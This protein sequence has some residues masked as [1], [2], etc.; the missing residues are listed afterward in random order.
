MERSCVIDSC[1]NEY[2]AKGYCL[3]HYNEFYRYN[4]SNAKPCTIEGCDRFVFGRG[5]CRRHYDSLVPER[6]VNNRRYRKM[7]KLRNPIKVKLAKAK[8]N[9]KNKFGWNISKRIAESLGGSKRSRPWESLVGYTLAELKVHLEARFTIGMN[10][11]RY[12]VFGW[13]VDHII[14]QSRFNFNDAEDI[15]FKLCWS[16]DN[17]QPLWAKDNI[18][19]SDKIDKPFQPS[20]AI[21]KVALYE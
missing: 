20:L 2:R 16:L 5:F 9:S 11:D 6:V 13:H 8:A 18:Y 7:W 4:R 19:K 21:A 14:P 17:L 15:D 1:I 3:K 10:W 12:G